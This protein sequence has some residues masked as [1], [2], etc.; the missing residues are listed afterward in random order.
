[1]DCRL[2]DGVS[3]LL[4]FYAILRSIPNKLLGV[5]AMISA[6]LII[7]ALPRVDLGRSRGLAFRPLSKMAFYVF[8][9]NF[10]ILMQLGA[11][12][13]EDPFIL[14]GQISTVLYF[15]HFLFIIPFFSLVE[16]TLIDLRSSSLTKNSKHYSSVKSY[17][18]GERLY[19]TSLPIENTHIDLS[20]RTPINNK[21]H[22]PLVR[23]S[24]G[25]SRLY[26][27]ALPINTTLSAAVKSGNFNERFRGFS[28]TFINRSPNDNL[29]SDVEKEIDKEVHNH[30]KTEVHK[31]KEP[32]KDAILHERSDSSNEAMSKYGAYIEK[33]SKK[34]SQSAHEE[35]IQS[36]LTISQ[37]IKDKHPDLSPEKI[38]EY[39]D[40]QTTQKFF[41]N[42]FEEFM[43]PGQEK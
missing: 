43:L 19:S 14:L 17:M 30:Y 24:M 6:I 23:S 29:P 42:K 38:E 13:V 21:K 11:K 31:F 33:H 4:P 40:K 7:L 26:S 18:G 36:D 3:D 34:G 2:S 5:I 9:A 32:I 16:N 39:V 20:S 27:T 10:L 25:G 8:V 15:G 12:H 41:S 35:K 37:K 28:T 1:M 22:Y